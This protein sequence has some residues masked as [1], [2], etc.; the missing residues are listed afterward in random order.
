MGE[1]DYTVK[2]DYTMINKL[3]RPKEIQSLVPEDEILV[4]MAA[5]ILI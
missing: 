1:L 2:Y 4:F 3:E 5:I